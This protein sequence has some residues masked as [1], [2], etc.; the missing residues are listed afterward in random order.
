MSVRVGQEGEVLLLGGVVR[1]FRGEPDLCP[2]CGKFLDATTSLDSNDAPSPGDVGICWGCLKPH[3]FDERLARRRPT[4][5]ETFEIAASPN[6]QVAITR[7]RQF[8]DAEN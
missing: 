1:T 2:Y 6:V 7:L 3:V 5:E 4:L 8:R